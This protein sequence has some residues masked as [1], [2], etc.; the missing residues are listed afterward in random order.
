[1][2]I[3][4]L[5]AGVM[6]ALAALLTGPV[7]STGLDITTSAGGLLHTEALQLLGMLLQQGRTAATEVRIAADV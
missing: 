4:M 1:M 3:E 6:P 7:V 2:Q 5:S